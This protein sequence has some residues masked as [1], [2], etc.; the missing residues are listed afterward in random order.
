MKKS[1]TQR[2]DEEVV[3]LSDFNI[4]LQILYNVAVPH[5]VTELYDLGEEKPP[6]GRGHLDTKQ[7]RRATVSKAMICIS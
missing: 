6:A 7:W 5:R 4:S 1:C 2:R 3:T